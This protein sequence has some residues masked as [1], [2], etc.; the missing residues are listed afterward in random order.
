ML[1]DQ[2]WTELVA[3]LSFRNVVSKLQ[4]VP[5]L[6]YPPFVQDLKAP[7]RD[8]FAPPMSL[9]Q[10][11]L[12]YQLP[13]TN[14]KDQLAL[15]M[16][17][18]I[19]NPART[20]INDDF[21]VAMIGE[22][23]DTLYVA[24]ETRGFSFKDPSKL[25]SPLPAICSKLFRQLLR[26]AETPEDWNHVYRYCHKYM[27][28]LFANPFVAGFPS[29]YRD[30]FTEIDRLKAKRASDKL[31]DNFYGARTVA[32]NTGVV[33][34]NVELVI[35]LLH[36]AGLRDNHVVVALAYLSASGSCRIFGGDSDIT[37]FTGTAGKG[38]SNILNMISV[39]VTQ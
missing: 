29:I 13:Y 31:M 37:A 36:A 33:H 23:T 20:A 17:P 11:K 28:M 27:R 18:G 26:L 34:H 19:I 8:E 21:D 35:A 2:I 12:I 10:Y 14:G 15:F 39:L 25:L 1:P 38:K 24:S 30:L 3:V 7:F 4:Q 5:G 32:S 22:S 6:K 9:V 16:L